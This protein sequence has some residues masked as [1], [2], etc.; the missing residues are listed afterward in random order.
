MTRRILLTVL[1]PVLVTL[2]AYPQ[3]LGSAERLDRA[4]RELIE[5]RSA[6][7]DRLTRS[8]LKELRLKK[9]Y[10]RS[11]IAREQQFQ[12]AAFV[13]R[14]PWLMAAPAFGAWGYYSPAW[15]NPYWNRR[16]VFVTP[17]D[18][19]APPARNRR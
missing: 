12:Q 14:N 7:K 9:R 6:D 5:L 2:K 15:N 3:D 1:L 18:R 16:P 10:L 4:Q 13:A 11:V 17:P 19:C 8:E